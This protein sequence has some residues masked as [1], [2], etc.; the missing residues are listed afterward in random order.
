MKL[1]LSICRGTALHCLLMSALCSSLEN[2]PACSARARAVPWSTLC[3]L[4]CCSAKANCTLPQQHSF[5]GEGSCWSSWADQTHIKD[6]KGTLAPTQDIHLFLLGCGVNTGS[7][8]GPDPQFRCQKFNPIW[9]AFTSPFEFSSLRHYAF[10]TE[11]SKFYF[12][13]IS[14][15]WFSKAFFNHLICS[16]EFYLTKDAFLFREAAA[17]VVPA[18][19]QW[20]S[21]SEHCS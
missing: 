17:K 7:S 3:A 13:L 18:L 9:N 15:F 6:G 8:L 2:E 10:Q 16:F 19:P 12:F 21:P 4:P 20:C 11:N 1:S 5:L 14:V